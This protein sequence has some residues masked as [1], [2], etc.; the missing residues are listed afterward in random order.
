M[1]EGRPDQAGGKARAEFHALGDVWEWTSQRNSGGG[2]G[3]VAVAAE[4]SP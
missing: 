1:E 4:T 2:R 3:G